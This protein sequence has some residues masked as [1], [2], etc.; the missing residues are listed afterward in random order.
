MR[1][2]ISSV[3]NNTGTVSGKANTFTKTNDKYLDDSGFILSYM[4]LTKFIY[5][6]C[7][8]RYIWYRK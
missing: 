8:F 2:R 5:K 3:I 1:W 6:T 7:R 4:I